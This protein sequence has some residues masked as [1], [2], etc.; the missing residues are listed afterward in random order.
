MTGSQELSKRLRSS[1]DVADQATPHDEEERW[2]QAPVPA[3]VAKLISERVLGRPVS[4]D[5]IPLLTQLMHWSYG[6]GWGALY[7]LLERVL[8]RRAQAREGPVLGTAIWLMS[9]AQLVPM[10]LYE[11]PWR[12]PPAELGFDLSH[13]LIYGTSTSFSLSLLERDDGKSRPGASQRPMR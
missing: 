7:A 10:G 1:D 4:A 5:L 9:Y 6:I 2:D 12:Y 13:H 8:Q 3:Q 11:P